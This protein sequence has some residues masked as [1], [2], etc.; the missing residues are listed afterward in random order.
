M[1]MDSTVSLDIKHVANNAFVQFQVWDFP[2]DFD[3]ARDELVY[4]GQVVAPH[5][6]FAGASALVYVVDAQVA[7]K[8]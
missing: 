2:G 5:V 6:A 8:T 7:K 1:F 3:F 4:G